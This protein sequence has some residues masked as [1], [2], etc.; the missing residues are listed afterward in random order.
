LKTHFNG[1]LCVIFCGLIAF[2]IVHFY[3]L[4]K[5]DYCLH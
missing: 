5:H 4:P 3:Y 2:C 1:V